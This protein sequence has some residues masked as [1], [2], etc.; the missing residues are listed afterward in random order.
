M[1]NVRLC[2][3][4][5][6]YKTFDDTE[7]CVDSMKSLEEPCHIIIVDNFSDNGSLEKIRE[8]YEDE[9]NIF[10]IENEKNLGYAEGIQK[11]YSYAR[12]YL[13]DRMIVCTNND[14]VIRDKDF[15]ERVYQSFEKSGFH[16]AG[17]DIISLVDAGHQNPM[18]IT[19]KNLKDVKKE[20]NR[21]RMLY[22]LSKIGIYDIL[23]KNKDRIEH[24]HKGV[25]LHKPKE[26]IIMETPERAE[27]V[28]LFGACYIF[29]PKF[30]NVEKRGFRAGTFLY[31]EE[32]IMYK[33]C[34]K[35]H[36]KVLYD[37]SIRIYHK[38]D[39]STNT[40]F[41]KNKEKREFIFKNMIQSLK[42]YCKYME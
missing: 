7:K 12:N 20:I 37:P 19:S 4:L 25:T 14:I 35:K 3:V 11:E 18:Q 9:D 26:K 36:Y 38:E 13:H 41:P 16:V 42:E 21:Y 32:N 40:I 34:K 5:L 28:C 30:V 22:F 17:P 8:K 15:V 27:G 29:S 6:H 24:K 2:F 23:K 1:N 31:M 10:I 39:S 33:Y